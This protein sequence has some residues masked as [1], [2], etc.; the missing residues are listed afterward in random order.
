MAFVAF[1]HCISRLDASILSRNEIAC[2]AVCIFDADINHLL[3]A[4]YIVHIGHSVLKDA[5]L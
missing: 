3:Q 5:L 2:L 1:C 4:V